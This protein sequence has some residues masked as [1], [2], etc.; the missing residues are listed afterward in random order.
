MAD[1]SWKAQAMRSLGDEQRR[2]LLA[3]LARRIVDLRMQ[4]ATNRLSATSELLAARRALARLKT[5]L[6]EK[7]VHEGQAAAKSAFD[8]ARK[9]KVEGL[10][11]ATQA[12][13]QLIE[14]NEKARQAAM[15]RKAKGKPKAEKAKG[16]SGT[17]KK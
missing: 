14:Q 5:I 17:G 2:M 11:A 3:D 1:K 8:N 16:K 9:S 6:H 4:Q 15:E 7:T 12:R 10:K 13:R